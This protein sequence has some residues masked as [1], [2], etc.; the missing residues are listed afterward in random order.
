[1][2]SHYDIVPSLSYYTCTCACDV[3]IVVVTWRDVVTVLLCGGDTV[4]WLPVVL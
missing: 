2:P 1:M 4:V 3:V